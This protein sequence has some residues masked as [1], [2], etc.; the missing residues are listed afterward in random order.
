MVEDKSA[1]DEQK[2]ISNVIII[3]SQNSM[4]LPKSQAEGEGPQTERNFLLWLKFLR[5]LRHKQ[6]TFHDGPAGHSN[7]V[8]VFG[9]LP[10]AVRSAVVN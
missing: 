4:S 5:T 10:A 7:L 3:Y 1:N 8:D 2:N 9:T 6:R